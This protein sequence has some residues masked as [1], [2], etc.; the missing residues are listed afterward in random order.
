[1]E[2]EYKVLLVED[3]EDDAF[4]FLRALKT[5]TKLRLVWRANTG[6]EA[7]DYLA[8]LGP[9]ADRCQYPY[10]DA[11]VLDLKLPGQD[12][13]DVLEWLDRQDHRPTVCVYSS[14]DEPCD[15]DRAKRLHAE[16]FVSKDFGL[17]H[18]SNLLHTIERAC[19]QTSGRTARPRSV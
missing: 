12:G 1:M 10:P 11:L 8:G 7:I 3:N 2:A 4:F 16:C 18:F 14:S 13:F 17:A 15:M 6:E 5:P 9:F 19:D